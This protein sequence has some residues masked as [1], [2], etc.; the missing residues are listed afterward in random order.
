MNNLLPHDAESER[1]VAGGILLLG[2]EGLEK[3]LRTGLDFP[4]FYSEP[5]RFVV[6]AAMHLA[7]KGKPIDA[8][9]VKSALAESGNLEAV[10][11]PFLFSL[12]DGIPTALNVEAYAERVRAKGI[13]RRAIIAAENF[14][15]AMLSGNGQIAPARADLDKALAELTQ[16]GKVRYSIGTAS[17]ALR[18][19][20]DIEWLL[21]DFLAR[22]WLSIWFGEPGCKKTWAILDQAVCVAMGLPWLGFR[23][24]RST[25]L[26]VDEESGEQRLLR[27]LGDAM[28]GHEA[29]G[30][31]PLY[32]V[33]L[34]GFNLTDDKGAADLEELVAQVKPGLVIIDAMADLMLGGDEN[35]VKDT[36]PI[37][38]R[39]R[40]IAE[41][42]D[43]AV[44][45]IHHVNKAGQYRGSTALKGAVDTMLLVESKPDNSLVTFTA[46]KSRDVVIR[47]FAATAH[48][49]IGTFHL[50]EADP[51]SGQAKLSPGERYVMKYLEA[52]GPATVRAI[53]DNADAC[54]GET[55]RRALY[56]L[57]GK[58]PP[59]VRR[60]NDNGTG[61]GHE[62]VYETVRNN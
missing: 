8:I 11:A 41:R 21:R 59:M 58:Q 3:A 62:A 50:S 60:V 22:R 56:N 19:Q 57:A 43:C 45:V 20:P 9:T 61:K 14:K 7:A 36:Q 42:Q 48:F 37:L 6:R 49:D 40:R 44:E 28:R 17:K 30:D 23:A 51:E 4:D 34:H 29:P 32:Y 2:T 15:T 16:G 47:P 31:I 27:R 1:A 35:L 13:E 10:G 25:V 53:M 12:T 55:A 52:N 38:V 18:P 46:E 26:I 54:S 24:P 5:C 33:T 39:L